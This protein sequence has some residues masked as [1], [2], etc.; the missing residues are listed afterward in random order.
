MTQAKV[1][2]LGSTGYAGG[3]VASRLIDLGYAVT[4]Q[5]R[6]D[7]SRA[8]ELRK[9]GAQVTIGTLDSTDLIKEHAAR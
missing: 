2:V 5:V 1:L 6:N 9:R 4:A 7:D 8:E 3:P